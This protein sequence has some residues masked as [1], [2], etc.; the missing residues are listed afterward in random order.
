ML[1]F[2]TRTMSAL[3][4]GTTLC[5]LLLLAGWM[6][7]HERPS[8]TEYSHVRRPGTMTWDRSASI[9]MVGGPDPTV[10]GNAVKV[11][12]PRKGKRA[13]VVRLMKIRAVSETMIAGP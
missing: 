1:S 6:D 2:R 7:V 11:A 5:T 13:T 12:G 3:R 8:S 10:S 9:Q 4:V